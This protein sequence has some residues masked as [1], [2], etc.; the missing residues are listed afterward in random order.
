MVW[1]GVDCSAWGGAGHTR[2]RRSSV[3]RSGRRRG[4][5]PR[6]GAL[7]LPAARLHHTRLHTSSLSLRPAALQACAPVRTSGTCHSW[8]RVCHEPPRAGAPGSG[9]A[10]VDGRGSG[11]LGRWGRADDGPEWAASSLPVPREGVG[12]E[13]AH[14][15]SSRLAPLPPLW[16]HPR[17]SDT[18][19]VAPQAEPGEAS[20]APALAA[21]RQMRRVPAHRRLTRSC[22]SHNPPAAVSF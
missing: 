10:A 18:M 9:D 15:P 14:A 19:S 6:D 13:R 4:W 3:G 22:L 21:W 17:P 8:V 5:R 20:C 16:Q 12:A 7:R 2:G 11:E 1:V